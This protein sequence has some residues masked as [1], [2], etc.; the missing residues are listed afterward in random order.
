VNFDDSNPKPFAS[1]TPVRASFAASFGTICGVEVK[2]SMSSDE[3]MAKER[4]PQYQQIKTSGGIE[5][6]ALRFKGLCS[7]L[8]KCQ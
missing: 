5:K 2:S 3:D 1:A 6:L 8:P 7:F 4:G